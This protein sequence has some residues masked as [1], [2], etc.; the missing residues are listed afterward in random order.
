MSGIVEVLKSEPSFGQTRLRHLIIIHGV[1]FPFVP[2]F[3]PA[4]PSH[5]SSA[6]PQRNVGFQKKNHNSERF[7]SEPQLVFREEFVFVAEDEFLFV[8]NE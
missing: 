1:S 5:L 2:S 4:S 6:D 3:V 7:H 8:P